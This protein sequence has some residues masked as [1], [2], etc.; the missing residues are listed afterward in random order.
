[1]IDPELIAA[2]ILLPR[3]RASWTTDDS[4]LKSGHILMYQFQCKSVSLITLINIIVIAF[5]L[6]IFLRDKLQISFRVTI[7]ESS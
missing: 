1:M 2:A 6:N 7:S 5:E 4:F 3:F